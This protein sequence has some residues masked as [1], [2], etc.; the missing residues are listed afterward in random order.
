MTDGKIERLGRSGT[1][2]EALEDFIRDQDEVDASVSSRTCQYAHL[3]CRTN[4]NKGPVHTRT[5]QNGAIR[6]FMVRNRMELLMGC[7]ES[8]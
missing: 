2:E 3:I 4:Y 8:N 1:I 6:F 7:S 5:K